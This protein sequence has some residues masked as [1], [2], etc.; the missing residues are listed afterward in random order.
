MYWRLHILHSN[1]PVNALLPGRDLLL[2]T[3]ALFP[4]VPTESLR[5][6][7]TAY[8]TSETIEIWLSPDSLYSNRMNR[9][10]ANSSEEITVLRDAAVRV[11]QHVVTNLALGLLHVA[12]MRDVSEAQAVLQY[13]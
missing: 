11:G 9:S 4:V 12:A 1:L 7:E 10:S 3:N 2:G 13:R 6:G 8:L 5:D